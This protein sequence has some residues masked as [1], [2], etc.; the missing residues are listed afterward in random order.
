LPSLQLFDLTH[1]SVVIGLP[2]KPVLLRFFRCVAKTGHFAAQGF[3]ACQHGF[4]GSLGLGRIRAVY[5]C[6]RGLECWI[7]RIAFALECALLGNFCLNR[8]D[9]QM[10]ADSRDLFLKRGTEGLRL[11]V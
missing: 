7:Q 4:D 10:A 9:L 5:L 2:R 8:S 1:G 11:L 3:C 6:K